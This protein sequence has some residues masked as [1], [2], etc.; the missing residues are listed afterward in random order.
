MPTLPS[1]GGD[2]PDE[3]DDT[4]DGLDAALAVGC[5]VGE[6]EITGKLGEG[7]FGTVY[8]A[9]HP[10]IGKQAAVKVLNQEFSSNS[11]MVK[12]F[13]AEARAANT[14]RHANIIDIFNFGTLDDGRHY[15][16]M[17]LLD[18]VPLDEYLKDHGP[19]QPAQVVAVLRGVTRAL[20]A[21][22]DKG[23]V[24][25]DLKPE[26]ILLTFNEDGQPLPKLLDFGIAKLLGDARSISGHKTR[27][28]TPIGTPS[29]MSPEQCLGE[30]IDE[31][32][33]VYAFGVVCFEALSGELPFKGTSFLELMNKQVGAERPAVSA[34][35]P[36]LG[37]GLDEA[38]KTIMAIDKM[39]RPATPGEALA[40]LV[41]AAREG[42]HDLTNAPFV[43]KP[44]QQ[45]TGGLASADTISSGGDVGARD[46]HTLSSAIL[47]ARSSSRTGLIVAGAL[48]LSIAGYVMT[49]QL[50]EST[51]TVT[52]DDHPT[53]TTSLPREPAPATTSLSAVTTGHASTATASASESASAAAAT[54]AFRVE[55][56]PT[57]AGAVVS[58]DDVVLGA[59]PGPFET[60][61]RD[62]AST[63]VVKAPGYQPQKVVAE[64]TQGQVVTVKLR[65][66]FHTPKD[67][68][69]PF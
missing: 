39:Q 67:L 60:T 23:I 51:E 8:S 24:H 29:H 40:L 25:R 64:L 30:E 61:A 45:R 57:V 3:A 14:I 22:H 37:D 53:A 47:G 16:V 18:G 15:F 55:I 41:E 6:Y 46:A 10:L 20:D 62:D 69:D 2:E 58:L 43:D 66:V 52:A 65:K 68:E 48:A 33:D 9:V 56:Q 19:L 5:A 34:R 13:I 1:G 17:E 54:V 36:E 21:A 50:T 26:N 11:E 59:P 7:G 27:T 28:G 4:D 42:G 12:R 32:A 49:G 38:L 31:R 35:R 44:R 63:I